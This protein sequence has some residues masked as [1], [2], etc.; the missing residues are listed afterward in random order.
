MPL[1][2]AHRIG[3][4]LK[5]LTTPDNPSG[6]SNS[7]CQSVRALISISSRLNYQSFSDVSM[8]RIATQN[9]NHTSSR[10]LNVRIL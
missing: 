8:M 7:D 2:N 1:L 4:E 3:A 9:K 6:M 10:V 5:T